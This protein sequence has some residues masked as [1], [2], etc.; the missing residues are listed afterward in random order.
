MKKFI[1]C[2]LVALFAVVATRLFFTILFWGLMFVVFLFILGVITETISSWWQGK[3][4]ARFIN[5]HN[6]TYFLWY[7]SNKRLKQTIER[8]LEL[9][10]DMNYKKIYINKH[11]PETELSSVVYQHLFVQFNGIKFP[12]IVKIKNG[13]IVAKSFYE[14]VYRLKEG[15]IS[16]DV[17]KKEVLIKLNALKNE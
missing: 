5:K 9:T 1:I 12:R 4:V 16:P 10:L 15:I 7:S 17:F 3:E 2:V 8:H 6:G 13:R 11:K 14:E